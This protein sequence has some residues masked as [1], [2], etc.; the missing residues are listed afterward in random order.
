MR[1]LNT[2]GIL[3]NVVGVRDVGLLGTRRN[4]GSD[5]GGLEDNRG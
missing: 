5:E 2:R 3:V 1:H 4:G